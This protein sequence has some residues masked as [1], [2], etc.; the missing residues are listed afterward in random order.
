M[1][2]TVFSKGELSCRGCL[3][4]GTSGESPELFKGIMYGITS[5]G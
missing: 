4:N 1:V 2:I 3:Q 5:G